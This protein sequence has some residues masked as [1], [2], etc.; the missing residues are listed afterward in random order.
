VR[1]VAHGPRTADDVALAAAEA[2]EPPSEE[3]A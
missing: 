1:A 3:A 2:P